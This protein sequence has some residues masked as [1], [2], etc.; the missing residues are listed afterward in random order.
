MIRLQECFETSNNLIQLCFIDLQTINHVK[1]WALQLLV[2]SLSK[3]KKSSSR[4]SLRS[5]NAERTP[6]SSSFLQDP[7]L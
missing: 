1:Y 4:R 7:A 5:G 2:F 6:E 3:R